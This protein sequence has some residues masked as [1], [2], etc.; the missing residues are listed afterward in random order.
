MKRVESETIILRRT[1]LV[2]VQSPYNTTKN[3]ESY[4]EEFI[5]L[6]KS[7]GIN[8][9]DVFYVKLRSVDPGY[10]LTSGKLEELAARVKELEIDEVVFSEPLLTQQERNLNEVL[11]CKVFDRTQLILEIFEKGATSAEGKLQVELA[12]LHHK[13]SRLAG[14]GIHMSQQTGRIGTRGPGETAKEKEIQHIERSMNKFKEEL[15]QLAKTRD[16]QRKMRLDRNV[17]LICL[18]GYTNAGKSTIINALTHANVLAEDKLFATLDTT[19][20]E[21]YINK[22]KKGLISDTVGFVQ[23]LP[24]HL[25]EAFKSTLSELRYAHLLLEV[26]DLSDA[27]FE[28]HIHVVREVL[29]ELGVDKPILYVFNKADK[30][31]SIDA[32][33]STINRYQPHIVI[34]ATTVEGLQPLVDYLADWNPVN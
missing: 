3:I 31:K 33:Q 32:V 6:V 24:H 20:R 7:N 25:I 5:N 14:R 17:P 9:I 4:F 8:Y 21:L 22:K 27:N 15:R 29:D 1:L 26:V 19:T 34:N 13:K 10:F 28:H 30:V 18:I 12:M 2:A 16:T 11:R 23:Q